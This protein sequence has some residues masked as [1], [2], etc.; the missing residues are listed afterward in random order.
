[1]SDG[2]YCSWLKDGGVIWL[3][4]R[5]GCGKSMLMEHMLDSHTSVPSDHTYLSFAFSKSFGGLNCSAL[6]LFR[7]LLHQ[8]L[9]PDSSTS[10]LHEFLAQSDFER[11]CSIQGEPEKK[12]KWTLDEVRRATERYMQKSFARQ[13][14]RL[15]LDALDEADDGVATDVLDVLEDFCNSAPTRFSLCFSSRP[16][17]KLARFGALIVRVEDG[18]TAD[19]ETFIEQK[20]ASKVKEFGELACRDAKALLI[21]ESNGLLL[22]LAWVIDEVMELVGQVPLEKFQEVI[23]GFPDQLDDIYLQVLARIKPFHLERALTVF[24]RICLSKKS[25]RVS[26]LRCAVDFVKRS[27][28]RSEYGAPDSEERQVEH[29]IEDNAK[30]I[31]KVNMFSAGLLKTITVKSRSY[32]GQDISEDYLL[33]DHAS[34]Q[35]FMMKKG[36][37]QLHQ[38]LHEENPP[39]TIAAMHLSMA[40][41]CLQR[42]LTSQRDAIAKTSQ[43]FYIYAG[44]NFRAHMLEAEKEVAK[45]GDIMALFRS[46]DPRLLN[47]RSIPFR[48]THPE[49]GSMPLGMF[50]TPLH[51]ICGLGLTDTFLTCVP[52]PGQPPSI[53]SAEELTEWLGSSDGV[54]AEEGSEDLALHGGNGY[55]LLYLA[56]SI[57]DRPMVQRLLRCGIQ[58]SLPIRRDSLLHLAVRSGRGH[59]DIIRLL[60]HHFETDA[61]DKNLSGDSPLLLATENDKIDVVKILLPRSDNGCH[62]KASC[63][64]TTDEHK[65]QTWQT[66]LSSA[67]SRGRLSMAK[68]LM[69]GSDIDAE[70]CVRDGNTILH[71][72]GNEPG[73]MRM[74]LESDEFDTTAENDEEKTPLAVAA[75]N[76]AHH[77]VKELLEDCYVDVTHLES[78][79]RQTP[80]EL[81]IRGGNPSSKVAEILLAKQ[82]QDSPFS[83]FEEKQF[84]TLYHVVRERKETYGQIAVLLDEFTEKRKES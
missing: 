49:G 36:L 30:F 1:M 16:Y 84:E 58:D 55:K 37:A 52:E 53:I 48:L 27:I 34:V 73:L 79:D 2:A 38:Q 46:H 47:L 83:S 3:R 56:V 13:P 4:G 66:P 62:N 45:R 11:K 71:E 59:L 65:P 78:K 75:I 63:C 77:I 9:A 41:V 44:Q 43:S 20:F 61:D 51:A 35:E 64:R 69:E 39:A 40:D 23:K 67:V 33:C 6:G 19:V 57:E 29:D 50:T 82:L 28:S 81:A 25:L 32:Y 10:D 22:W 14:V 31:N 80:L 7:S 15:Y 74:L 8:L 18:N 17:P 12:W 54:T 70:F 72:C 5:P 68:M 60:L 21:K 42:V 24:K 26:E 76:G